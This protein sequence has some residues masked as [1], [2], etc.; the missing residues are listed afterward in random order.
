MSEEE[1]RKLKEELK[2]EILNEMT[3]K[4]LVKDNTWKELKKEFE[5]MF[6][7]KGYGN[8]AGEMYQIFN[9]MSIIV[10]ISTGYRTVQIIPVEKAE[11][12]RNIMYKVLNIFPDKTKEIS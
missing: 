11:D 5:K 10:R 1:I 12:I 4:Q 8:K 2:K 3:S 6:Y 7:S 9:A